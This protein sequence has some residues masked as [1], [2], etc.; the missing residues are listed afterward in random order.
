[1]QANFGRRDELTVTGVYLGEEF[2]DDNPMREAS[3]AVPIQGAGSVI[4]V[5]A[6]D[7]PLFPSQ[8]KAFARRVTSG[9]ARTGTS[10]SHFSG[11]MFLA[12]STANPGGLTS[13]D[14]NPNAAKD[15]AKDAA[16]AQ[17]YD[18]L[19]FIP[20]DNLDP[21]FEAVV[22]ATE[23]AVAQR[24]DRQRGHDRPGRPPH[25]GAAPGPAR[26]DRPSQ[27]HPRLKPCQA[28]P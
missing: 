11:D 25:P 16:K 9:L 23:E 12:F 8:C 19:T 27:Q 15:A 17:A 2:A 10:G 5:V 7:A 21:F 28:A 20:W 4:A 6:T 18:Q 14:P 13:G 3:N 22:Q 24:P 26:R 1:M